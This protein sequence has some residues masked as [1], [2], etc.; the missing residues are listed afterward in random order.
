MHYKKMNWLIIAGLIFVAGLEIS[1]QPAKQY[2]LYVGTFTSEG[3]EGIYRC[4]FNSRN[5]GKVP[6]PH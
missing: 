2:D 1:A 4:S 6:V 3:A 5:S